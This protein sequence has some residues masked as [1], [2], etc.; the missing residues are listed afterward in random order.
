MVS[1]RDVG[2]PRVNISIVCGPLMSY[3]AC[4]TSSSKWAM[5]PS[6]SCPCMRIPCRNVMRDFS[7][8]RVSANCRLKERRQLSHSHLSLVCTPMSTTC[9]VSH[10]LMERT[11]SDTDFPWMYERNNMLL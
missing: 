9:V 10:A 2:R 11:H 1:Y 3:P 4:R 7:F 5:Y 8:W 6:R